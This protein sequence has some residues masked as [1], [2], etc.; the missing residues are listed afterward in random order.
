MDRLS[1][2]LAEVRSERDYLR[3][4]HA[5][6]VSGEQPLLTERAVEPRRRS[7]RPWQRE[8]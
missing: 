2:L 4:V 8:G 6:A 5:L 3:Q 1:E 7:R